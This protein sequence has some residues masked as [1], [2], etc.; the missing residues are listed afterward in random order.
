[1]LQKKKPI[2]PSIPMLVL[3]KA[4]VHVIVVDPHMVII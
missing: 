1:L 3:E 4:H 2:K